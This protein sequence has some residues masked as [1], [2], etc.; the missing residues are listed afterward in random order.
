MSVDE[1]L[2]MVFVAHYCY[3]ITVSNSFLVVKSHLLAVVDVI[4]KTKVCYIHEI[5]F[6]LDLSGNLETKRAIQVNL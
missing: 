1:L 4:I 2:W 6:Q 5:Q 3:F